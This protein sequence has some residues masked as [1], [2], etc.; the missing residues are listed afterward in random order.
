MLRRDGSDVVTGHLD[1]PSR[2]AALRGREAS[3][4]DMVLRVTRDG[5]L[6]QVHLSVRGASRWLRL[7][8]DEAAQ[9]RDGPDAVLGGA[10]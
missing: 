6:V 4:R 9:L 7:T 10:A 1:S 2:V 8:D 3:E 5:G